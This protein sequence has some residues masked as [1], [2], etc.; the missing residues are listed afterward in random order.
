MIHFAMLCALVVVGGCFAVPDQASCD[1]RPQAQSCTDLLENKNNQAG[2]TLDALCAGTYSEDLCDTTGA[3]GGCQCD[4]CE[5]GKSVEWL[6]PD[7]AKNINTA[8]DVMA[9]CATLNRTFVTP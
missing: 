8:A 9:V 3:L 1:G 2:T 4:G 5:N 7:P 6:F